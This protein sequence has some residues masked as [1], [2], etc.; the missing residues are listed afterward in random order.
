[1]NED[2]LHKALYLELTYWTQTMLYAYSC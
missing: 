1:L 2:K